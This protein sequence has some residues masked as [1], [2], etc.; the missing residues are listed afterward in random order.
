M[1]A[2][3]SKNLTEEEIA[4]KCGCGLKKLS[5]RTIAIFQA[6]RDYCGFPLYITSGCRC[7]SHNKAVGGVADSAHQP[8]T[9]GECQALDLRF[10]NSQQL[11][12]I[13][14]G[15]IKAGCNRIGINFAKSFVHYDT[16]PGK[17]QNVI[18]KY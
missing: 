10:G 4:C 1:A 14:S 17:P 15:L 9:Q 13:I 2:Y 18:F 12:K 16:D 5:Q 8:N 11:Y 6:T 7:P 3:L